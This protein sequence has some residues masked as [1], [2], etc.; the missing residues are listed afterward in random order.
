MSDILK[1]NSEMTSSLIRQSTLLEAIFRTLREG[2]IVY[3]TKG[4]IRDCNPAA[5]ELLGLTRAQLE[6]TQ[7][8][9]SGWRMVEETGESLPSEKHPVA[10]TLKTGKVVTQMIIGVTGQKGLY[11]WLSCSTGLIQDPHTKD[12]DGIILTIADVSLIKATENSLKI[13]NDKLTAILSSVTDPV[14]ILDKNDVFMEYFYAQGPEKLFMKP[15]DFLFK[16][17]TQSPLERR[18][19]DEIS[20]A[21]ESLHK[22]S[23]EYEFDFSV[24]ARE[25]IV[26]YGAKFF[27]I[28]DSTENY[29]GAVISLRDITERVLNENRLLEDATTD[30]L[31]H[32]SNRKTLLKA[33][34]MEIK[35]A[36]RSGSTFSLIFFDID[37]FKAVNDTYGHEAGDRVLVHVAECVREQIRG[38]DSLARWGGE[39]FLIL[40]PGSSLGIA[41]R[42]ADRL[43]QNLASRLVNGVGYV[44]ASFGV[45]QYKKKEESVSVIRRADDAMYI[46]KKT[47][48]NK[49]TVSRK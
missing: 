26:Y 10:V 13:F 9:P 48:R 3:D 24:S 20:R 15:K 33:I 39:E 14:F 6:G 4:K 21:V 46:S 27:A 36:A 35:K 1:E 2:M 40:L 31:T 5:A 17:I 30:A 42:L 34:D 8:K 45:A 28:R 44:T 11:T 16:K 25:G 43:R 23:K 29:E 38:T 19:V 49:V 32:A 47:G 41:E 7:S 22:G 18:V 37:H 12:I